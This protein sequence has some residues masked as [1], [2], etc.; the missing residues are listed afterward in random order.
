MKSQQKEKT[1]K[2]VFKDHQAF[3]MDFIEEKEEHFT[4]PSEP[5]KVEMANLI[6][7]YDRFVVKNYF[8]KT[9]I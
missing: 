2:K 8:M 9:M 5:W 6:K 7:F 4:V 3:M 1:T